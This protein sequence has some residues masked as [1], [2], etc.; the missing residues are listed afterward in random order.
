LLVFVFHSAFPPS[1]EFFHFLLFLSFRSFSALLLS[2]CSCISFL[3][4]Y[5]KRILNFF[6]LSFCDCSSGNRG[7]W[8]TCMKRVCSKQARKKT[9]ICKMKWQ[10]ENSNQQSI[11]LLSKH[12]EHE[13]LKID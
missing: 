4:F 13:L 6:S 3:S 10:N 9:I 1:G 2:S 11:L 12:R 5:P 7:E 8:R